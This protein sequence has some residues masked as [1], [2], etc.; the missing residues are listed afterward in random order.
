MLTAKLDRPKEA[1]EQQAQ[2][3]TGSILGLP[4]ELLLRT[5][6]FLSPGSIRNLMVNRSLRSVCE[7]GLYH[8]ISLPHHPCRSIHLVETFILR[9][10]LASLVRHLAIDFSWIYEGVFPEAQLPSIIQPDALA[11][12]S[13]AK[14]VQSLI[15]GGLESWIWEPELAKFREA[16]L[17]MKLA[18]LEV[19]KLKDPHVEYGFECGIYINSDGEAAIWNREP[20]TWGGDLGNEIRKLLQAQ[21][22]LEELTFPDSGISDTTEESLKANLLASDVPNL[23]S[24]Q[25]GPGLAMAFLRVA[26]R[27]ESLNVM[28]RLWDSNLL[29]EME[30]SSAAIKLSI[31]RF[32]IRVWDC[33]D[34]FWDNIAAV[35]SLFPNT[36]DLS[37][38]IDSRAT[39]NPANYFF[40]KISDSVHVL[41]SLRNLDVE[42]ETFYSETPKIY[43]VDIQ[44]ITNSKTACPLLETVVE[45]ERRLWTFRTDRQELAGFEARLV[46]PLMEK[47]TRRLRDLPNPKES[48]NE[49]D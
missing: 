10:D 7:Q 15:L 41:P 17:E 40:R 29:S 20:E 6:S 33:D 43:E 47:P 13:L 31:R 49:G 5:I 35:L 18:R 34:W 45:P 46:G 1:V 16:V 22:L 27:L 28:L 36:E 42:F 4:S 37:V 9:P 44:S 21:P 11:A 12:L 38:T 25:A 3:Q 26:P 39:Q 23:K 24:L 30:T 48:K 2:L 19:P 14:N 8:T 32:S